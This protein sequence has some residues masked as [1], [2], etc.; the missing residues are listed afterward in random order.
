MRLLAEAN[1]FGRIAAHDGIIGDIVR[2]Y[3]ACADN[4]VRPYAFAA[5]KDNRSRANPHITGYHQ[6]LG[7]DILSFSDE[8]I[9]ISEGVC[10]PP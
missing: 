5:G 3:G 7:W 2:Y 10:P 9:G 6:R 4:T 1:D 8:L